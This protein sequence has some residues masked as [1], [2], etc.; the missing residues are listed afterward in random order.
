MP[1]LELPEGQFGIVS[2]MMRRPDTA[3]PLSHLAEVLLRGPSTL[4]RGERELIAAYVSSLNKCRFCTDSHAAFASRQLPGGR[5]RVQ[6][7]LA[8]DLES[9][10]LSAKLQA[11]LGV[12]AEVQRS[13][14]PV[15]DKAVAAARQAGA[16][17]DELHDTV[18]IAAAFCMYNRYV[19]GLAT[20]PA[21]N[22][23]VYD[24]VAEII[25]QDGY[26]AAIANR[27]SP[28]EA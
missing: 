18:L 19:D 14:A 15:S 21:D 5:A 7:L 24:A 22:P 27:P 16:S 17:D 20:I 1:H 12:A 4:S 6:A 25:V 8:G 3:A 23:A 2:L 13:V 10:D 9:A 11:L 28:E 26:M